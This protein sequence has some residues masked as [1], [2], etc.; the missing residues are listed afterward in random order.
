VIEVKDICRFLSPI[1]CFGADFHQDGQ[2]LLINI[3]LFVL[4]VQPNTT[5]KVLVRKQN[6]AGVRAINWLPRHATHFNTSS[7]LFYRT[8]P[9]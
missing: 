2:L 5:Y 7:Q 1:H 4:K 6:S 3:I 9:H 8:L